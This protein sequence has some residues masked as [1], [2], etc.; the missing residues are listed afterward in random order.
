MTIAFMVP[1]A[2]WLLFII[3][4][5]IIAGMLLSLLRKRDR[6]RF[7]EPELFTELART[8]STVKQRIR[9]VAYICG[10]VLLIIA[11]T[12][13]RFGTKTEI[14]KRKG[15]DIVIA[16]DTSYSMLA[17]D[18]KPN[19]IE[20]AKYEIHHLIDNLRGDRISVLAFAGKAFVQCPLTTDYAAAKT[21]LDY[22]DVGIIS[23]PGTNIGDAITGS[24]KLLERGSVADSESQIIILFTD[25]ENLT[26]NPDEA[27][28]KAFDK[29]VR[30]FTIGIGSSSGEII[31]IRN[32]KGVIEDYK[33]DTGGN[34]VKTRLDEETL[35][36]IARITN[37]FY[38][39]TEQ[40][41][42]DIQTIIDHLNL[43]HKVDINEQK[44]TRL[45]EQYQIPLGASLFFLFIW[46][47][48]SERK[49]VKQ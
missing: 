38:M 26:G 4:F 39:R 48:M 40:G 19:R 41:E 33:K 24:L 44:V 12:D 27:A 46:M 25:G 20:Q 22:S 49:R 15:V 23:E 11:M 32:E 31:P 9:G 2:W 14:V 10:L 16:L 6:E 21:L 42:V 28:K 8:N 17:E 34:V 5:F 13:P 35:K 36:R 47:A 7:A 1:E 37:G 29:G 30:I 3:P 45:K 18:V 43:L